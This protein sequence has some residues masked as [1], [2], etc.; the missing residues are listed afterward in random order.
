M[1]AW[2]IA[3][4]RR[5]VAAAHAGRA[6]DADF[7]LVDTGLQRFE[8]L[9][10]AG[11]RAAQLV[12]DADGDLRRGLLAIDNDI[13]MGVERRDL[14]DL[15]QRH[16]HFLRQ[17]GEVPGVQAAIVVLDEVEVLDQQVFLARARAEKRANF[18]QASADRPDGPS[19]GR[20]S[21]DGRNRDGCSAG[22]TVFPAVEWLIVVVGALTFLQPCLFWLGH[23]GAFRN[24]SAAPKIPDTKALNA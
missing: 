17:G 23:F 10:G 7:A 19:A 18:F 12:A 8:Q 21:C 13:E 1:Q 22:D 3:V 9:F 16:P 24:I 2:P 11:E 4:D 15:D 20:A 6:D 14:V 5:V